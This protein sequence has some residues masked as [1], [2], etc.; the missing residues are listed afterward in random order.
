MVFWGL[1]KPSKLFTRD[2]VLIFV[3]LNFD[4][5]KKNVRTILSRIN[6]G[7]RTNKLSQERNKKKKIKIIREMKLN[8]M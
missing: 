8:T 1:I 7:L 2:A 5:K 6:K 4:A 3:I